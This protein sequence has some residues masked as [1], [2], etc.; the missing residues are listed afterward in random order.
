MTLELRFV[1]AKSD[2]TFAQKE[3]VTVRVSDNLSLRMY[4]DSRPHCK[5][6]AP[7]Q[8]GLILML[9]NRETVEE[10]V[11]F[12]V[13]VVKFQDHTFFCGSGTISF[14]QDKTGSYSKLEKNFVLDTIARK[15]VWRSAYINDSIY[16]RIHKGFERA[17][18][19]HKK[20]ST[21]FDTLM[22][23]RNLAKI[24][25]E[26]EKVEPRGLITVNYEIEAFTI[27]VHVDFSKLESESCEEMLILNE[28]GASYFG[29][30]VD[31]EGTE[32]IGSQIGPMNLV[33]ADQ[34]TMMDLNERLRFSLKKNKAAS[35]FRGREQTR[36]RFSWT[37]LS[38]S[39]RPN[40]TFLDY[41]IKLD[42]SEKTFV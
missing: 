14:K 33:T 7:L 3:P 42:Y 10:G 23:L 8:K 35:L 29:K 31:T 32:L 22:E 11:G 1:V 26:F 2:H 28:Q 21:F 19:P 17:Y 18:L 34:A 4:P 13:P 24:T 39:I 41:T 30:Y 38:Y 20:F 9:N 16:S 36:N 40:R 6:T 37:G 25:T 12:G 27:N 5:E 15:K